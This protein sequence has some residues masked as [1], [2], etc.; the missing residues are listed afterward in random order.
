METVRERT[1][2]SPALPDTHTTI[3]QAKDRDMDTVDLLDARKRLS[4]LIDRVESGASIGIARDGKLIAYQT[5]IAPPRKRIDVAALR[6]LT[7]TMSPA[8]GS[9]A[10]IV[11]SMR[12]DDR[13]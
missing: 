10:N 6:S 4:E 2:P 8:T 13:Y 5:A 7:S 1:G 9:A 3:H 12:D 11:R